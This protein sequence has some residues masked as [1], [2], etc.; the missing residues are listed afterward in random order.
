[1][2]VIPILGLQTLAAIFL[3][4]L[5]KLNR[6]VVMVFSQVSFPPLLPL[7]VLLSYRI[8]KY[9]M[10]G[11]VSETKLNTGT[12][13]QNINAHLEQYIYGSITLAILAA[14]TTGLLTFVILKLLK[15]IKQYRLTSTLKKR[16]YQKSI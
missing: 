15:A 3:A 5:F 10:G 11:S 9:W 8:G 16:L 14:I 6:A 2:G 1:M 7:V 12:S 13:V 4:M